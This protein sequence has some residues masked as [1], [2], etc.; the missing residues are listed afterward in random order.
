[1]FRNGCTGVF[2]D[3]SVNFYHNTT[4]MQTTELRNRFYLNA[5]KLFF[6]VAAADKVIRKEELEALQ[7]IIKKEWLTLDEVSDVFGT[8]AAFQIEF[9][10]DWLQEG[11]ALAKTCFDDFSAFKQEHPELFTPKINLLIQRTANAIA[12]AFSGKNKAEITL[13]HQ[14]ELLLT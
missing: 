11:A 12:G 10:F 3:I 9:M 14:L 7:Q 13:L 6:A 4:I 5:G 1:M 8:D 2:A